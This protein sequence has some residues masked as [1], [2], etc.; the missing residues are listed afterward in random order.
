MFPS[1]AWLTCLALSINLSEYQRLRR[2]PSQ[3]F[4]DL[5]RRHSGLWDR[6][7]G[8]E[9]VERLSGSR[10]QDDWIRC[11]AGPGWALV[12]DSGLHQDPW[13]GAGMGCAGVSAALLV[14]SYCAAGGT[15]TWI[16]AYEQRRDE[17][18]LD[19]FHDTVSG[20]AD[21]STAPP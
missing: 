11:A 5:V 16:H 7:A 8:A 20:A 18:M 9:R 14:E 13:S 10:P 3:R 6:Y 1:D 19:V 12:G 17:Q 15:D 21:L 4:D 2:D